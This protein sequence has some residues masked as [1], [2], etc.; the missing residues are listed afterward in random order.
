MLTGQ[1]LLQLI[2]I[3]LVVQ[4]FGNLSKRIGQQW[5]IGEILA[6]LALGPSLLGALWPSLEVQLFPKSTLPTLQTLG[7]IGLILYMFSLGARLDIHLMLRQSR[8]AVLVS[9]SGI[10]LPLV[11]GS[12]LGSFLYSSLAG[13][14][15]TF[16]SFILFVGTA[17]AITAFPVLARLLAEKKMLGTKV[18]M[19][20]LTCASVD[21]VIAWCLLAYVT[22]VA[23]SQK[24]LTVLG[25]V[26][27]T[28]LFAGVMLLGVRPL[29]SYAVRRIQSRSLQMALSI[30]VLLAAAYT[31]NSIGIHPVF[32]AFLAG[33]C[34]PRT[35]TFT[36]QVRSLDQV[37]T[38]LFL[39][40]FFVYSGLNTRFG[41]I[42]GLSLWL[43]CLLVLLIA[44][45]G[46]IIGGTL[47]TRAVGE[48][49]R[50][51]FSLGILMNTRGLV[52]LIVLNIGLELGVLS[53]TLFAMLVIMA[54]ITTMMASPLL[55][56]LG[57][58][59]DKLTDPTTET[60]L[61][62]VM[63]PSQ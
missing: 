60:D 47:S 35:V 9:L 8:S 46:K 15:A 6:G 19:L 23:H 63:E 48:S 39:P 18:G 52:E 5:V 55:P 37:N 12:L 58:R 34:L 26:G 62:D 36:K 50:D 42:N 40:V 44:C 38:V 7:D 3:L 2:V 21:D 24:T 20:A 4:L 56:L 10:I 22:S 25:T 16:L 57:Y 51:A 1:L 31:T 11:L 30:I 43:I 61:E 28:I 49:W 29:L 54:V 45:V 59:Q 33:I 13:P 53:Q 27:L 32:G 17:M 14:K 41:L